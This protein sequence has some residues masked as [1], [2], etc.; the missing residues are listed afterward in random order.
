M[1]VCLGVVRLQ[2]EQLSH[3]AV[4]DIV[5][6]ARAHQHDAVFEQPGVDV[7]GPLFA[8]RFFDDEGNKRHDWQSV[9]LKLLEF[10]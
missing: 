1:D 9:W 10:G 2:E 3:N 7:H 6:D 8:A 5:I 4:G